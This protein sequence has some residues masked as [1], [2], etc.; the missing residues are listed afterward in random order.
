MSASPIQCPDV[1]T[2]VEATPVNH[3]IRQWCVRLL[4]D[5]THT[6]EFVVT[7]LM[8]IFNKDFDEAY[9][10][11][12]QIHHLDA[13]IATVCSQERAEL[14]LEQVQSMPEDARRGSLGCEIEP[15]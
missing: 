8:T 11:T 5:E 9:H 6:V 14:Y 2:V 13:A 4:N 15:V 3:T 7:L 10:L 1:D 12:M